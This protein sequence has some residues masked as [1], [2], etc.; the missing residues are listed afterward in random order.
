MFARN[1]T[2]RLKSN[3]LSDYNRIFENDVLPLLQQ[4]E[5]LQG[6]NHVGK[7]GQPGCIAIS[8]WETKPVPT[9]TTQTVIRKC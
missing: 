9:L 1:V 8:L 4:T 6:R 5:G 7:F 3:K 2:F